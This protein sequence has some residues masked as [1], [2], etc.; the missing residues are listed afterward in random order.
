MK[1]YSFLLLYCLSTVVAASA[2]GGEITKP[3]T[4]SHPSDQSQVPIPK[5]P[6][7]QVPKS[8]PK[9]NPKSDDQLNSFLGDMRSILE[10]A[11]KVEAYLIASQLATQNIPEESVLAGYPVT[12]GPVTLNAEQ[13]KQAKS[14]VLNQQ[15]YFWGPPRKK[16]LVAPEIALRFI[17]ETQEVSVLLSTYCNLWTF[18]YQNAVK[19][20]DYEPSVEMVNQLIAVLFPTQ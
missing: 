17:H 18:A 1:K 8:I 4:S 3:S 10:Q 5:Q 20:Q 6:V 11:K 7:S 13:I 12:Q 2:G 14:L 16:C 15:N 19:T 9:A